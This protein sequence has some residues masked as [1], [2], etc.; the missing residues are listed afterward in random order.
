[1]S[2]RLVREINN[3]LT[4]IFPRLFN[5]LLDLGSDAYEEFQI[6]VR[7]VSERTTEQHPY[8]LCAAMLNLLTS[9]NLIYYGGFL[10]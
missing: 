9:Y 5:H 2:A 4:C 7:D 1:M 8:I 6:P 3:G 10:R